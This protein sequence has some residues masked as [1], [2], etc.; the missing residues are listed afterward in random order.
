MIAPSIPQNTTAE[1]IKIITNTFCVSCA[2]CHSASAS[3][4]S[5]SPHAIALFKSFSVYSKRAKSASIA[6]CKE[7]CTEA[8]F[9][10]SV[11]PYFPTSILPSASRRSCSKVLYLVFDRLISILFGFFKQAKKRQPLFAIC[12]APIFRL[13]T[14]FPNDVL[15]KNISFDS[16]F[17]NKRLFILLFYIKKVSMSIVSQ[18]SRSFFRFFDIF[19]LFIIF[20]GLIKEPQLIPHAPNQAAKT[21]L[22]P[23]KG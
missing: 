6:F 17:K 20:I 11:S 18:R 2:S 21:R 14:R 3:D 9:P 8:I 22:T 16:L 15:R 1:E 23:H 4:N 19:S 7:V 12:F 5:L 10:S 13:K